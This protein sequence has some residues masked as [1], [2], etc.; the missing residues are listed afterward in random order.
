MTV[1]LN[2]ALPGKLNITQS[3]DPGTTGNFDVKIVDTGKLLYSKLKYGQGKCESDAE[4]RILI[5]E[6][7][8]YYDSIQ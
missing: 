3:M 4:R 8:E 6:I 1:A 5:E 7:K 2:A